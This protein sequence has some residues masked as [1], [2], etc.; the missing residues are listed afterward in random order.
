MTLGSINMKSKFFKKAKDGDGRAKSF[1]EQVWRTE[2]ETKK[3]QAEKKLNI[4]EKVE[5][6]TDIEPTADAVLP[7]SPSVQA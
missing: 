4:D 2:Y 1:I 6:L 5:G 7:T 3:S